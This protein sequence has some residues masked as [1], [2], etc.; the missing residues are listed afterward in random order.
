MTTLAI[1][2]VKANLFFANHTIEIYWNKKVELVAIVFKVTTH[3]F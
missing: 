3:N 2:D 1:G